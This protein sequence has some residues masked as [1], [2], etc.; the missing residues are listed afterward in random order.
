M[1]LKKSKEIT[2]SLIVIILILFSLSFSGQTILPKIFGDYMVLQRNDSVKIW[3]WDSLATSVFINT[4]WNGST[5]STVV[6]S[7]GKWSVLV[8]TP[9]T[10]SFSN[11]PTAHTVTVLGTDT[12]VFSNVLI[13]EVWLC[14]GQSNMQ[15][16]LQGFGA[17]QPVENG[18]T[19]INESI[20]GY[21]NN[22]RYIEIPR[23][24]SIIA[25]DTLGNKNK[26]NKWQG[27]TTIL[28]QKKF[29]GAIAYM[30]AREM[31]DSLN[32][33][34]GV[35]N[36]ANGG[37]IIESWLDTVSTSKFSY[38]DSSS[39][40]YFYPDDTTSPAINTPSAVYNGMIHP[41]EGYGIRGML[42]YQG[43]GNRGRPDEY[44][45][46]LP[47]LVSSFRQKWDKDFP[48]YYVQIA[49]HSNNRGPFWESN[50]K[51]YYSMNDTLGQIGM[52]ISSDLGQYN[53]LC[54]DYVNHPPKKKE[55]AERLA[56]WAL[57]E[58]YGFIG[59]TK[60][61]PMSR[62]ALE[63][64]LG[65][66]VTVYFNFVGDGLVAN[67]NGMNNYEIAGAN[68]VYFPASVVLN[69]NNSITLQSSSVVAPSWV[70]T[71]EGSCPDSATL[72]NL[73]GLP[74]SA[75]TMEVN[76]TVNFFNDDD[77]FDF[78]IYPNPT[79]GNIKISIENFNGNI[80]TEVFDLIGNMLNNS[81][82]TTISLEGYDRGIY[83]IKV[84]YQG[85]VKELKVI[86]A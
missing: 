59:F 30:F 3:G 29:F 53:S 22:I 12:L 35:I 66:A 44:Q 7:N 78:S 69:A 8:S 48:F 85:Q 36:C 75:F 28:N 24:L 43:E 4:S 54:T 15:M 51:S 62:L 38:I 73:A 34:I 33:P 41:I 63:D 79:E 49:P 14:S 23:T 2:R 81:N 68:E 20:L 72:H 83:I 37:T 77:K 86:K 21:D 47:E 60:S 39:S 52:V 56:R 5:S 10:S 84:S 17:S 18:L 42:W 31:Y 64:N 1:M 6:N 26:R 80:K 61:G 67:P 55:I 71:G 70:R 74:A 50:R 58:N 9:D 25:Q 19:I 46:L 16:P 11:I 40:N 76:N 82:K 13:G 32:M 27:P 45:E 57:S 65:S